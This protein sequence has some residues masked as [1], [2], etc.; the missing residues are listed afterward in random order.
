M[1]QEQLY[2]LYSQ[3][4]DKLLTDK[5]FQKLEIYEKLYRLVNL[6]KTYNIPKE[7]IRTK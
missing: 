1:T 2:K 6:A 3:A 4:V 7:K 5:E